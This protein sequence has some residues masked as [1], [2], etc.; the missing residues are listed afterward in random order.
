MN[1]ASARTRI[2]RAL[3]DQLGSSTRI[4]AIREDDIPRGICAL[5]A[6]EGC[7]AASAVTEELLR[8]ELDTLE[9]QPTFGASVIDAALGVGCANASFL[10]AACTYLSLYFQELDSD[11][12][13][14]RTLLDRGDSDSV[15]EAA[16]LLRRSLDSLER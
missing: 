2:A 15:V 1:V 12:S 13:R 4:E 6:S 9:W 10:E 14:C 5:A 8:Q 11:I 3:T 16:I 7:D